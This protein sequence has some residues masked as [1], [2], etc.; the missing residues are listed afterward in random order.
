MGNQESD[1]ALSGGSQDPRGVRV[2]EF[3]RLSSRLLSHRGHLLREL[4]PHTFWTHVQQV[5]PKLLVGPGMGPARGHGRCADIGLPYSLGALLATHRAGPP[6]SGELRGPA[7]SSRVNTAPVTTHMSSPL[8]NSLDTEGHDRTRRQEGAGG[9]LVPKGTGDWRGPQSSAPWCSGQ[10]T[11]SPHM[12][13][14]TGTCP[15]PQP[16]HSAETGGR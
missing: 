15:L 12:S 4:V 2:R 3:P 1:T 14:H 7:S 8:Q 6:Q 10:T 11:Y 16:N 13:S 9:V 5:L